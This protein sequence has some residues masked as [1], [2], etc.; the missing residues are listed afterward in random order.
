M[1][2]EEEDQ[3][4]LFKEESRVWQKRKKEEKLGCGDIGNDEEEEVEKMSGVQWNVI[5]AVTY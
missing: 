2:D 4:N 5:L 1:E 3:E